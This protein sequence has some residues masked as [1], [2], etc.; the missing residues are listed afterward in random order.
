MK[1][2]PHLVH[3][4][5][6]I[7]EWELTGSHPMLPGD[8]IRGR[9]TFEWFDGGHFLIWR[10]TSEHKAIPNGM[11]IIGPRD[12]DTAEGADAGDCVMTYFDARGVS[13]IYQF[14][15]ER[16]VW[17][18]WRDSAD[19]AQRYVTTISDDGLTATGKGEMSKDGRPW[20][21]DLQLTYKRIH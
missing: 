19:L 13:R 6:M 14:A 12:A 5:P 21:P 11:S 17:R 3:L 2:H 20:Q 8:V 15:A 7:G 9:A 16:N 1:R 18:F 10:S 4:E